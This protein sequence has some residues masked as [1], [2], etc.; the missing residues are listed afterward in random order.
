MNTVVTREQLQTLAIQYVE[1]EKELLVIQ[2]KLLFALQRL[3]ENAVVV[4]GLLASLDEGN[5]IVCS[6]LPTLP[7]EYKEFVVK[8][9][10]I[11]IEVV[12]KQF[13][14]ACKT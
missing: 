3:Q 7:E 13:E 2:N 11:P 4:D 12:I 14:D 5:T 9:P 8:R 10:E 1:H 6:S